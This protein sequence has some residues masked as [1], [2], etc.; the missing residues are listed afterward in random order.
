MNKESH[1]KMAKPMVAFL[2]PVILASVLQSL[3]QVFGIIYV[4]QALGVESL[5]AISAF[6]PLFFFLISFAIGIGS[7]SSILVGQTYGGGNISKM[8]E[9]VGVTLAFT[10]TISIGV[11]VFGTLFTENILKWMGTPDDILLISAGYARILFITLPITF[12]YMVYTTFMRGVGDSK[13]PFYFLLVSV[14]TNIILLPISISGWFGFPKQGLNGAAYAA[15]LSSFIAFLFLMGYLYKRGHILKLDSIILKNFRL[16][17]PILKSLLKLAIPTSI[18]MVAISMSEIAVITFVNDYG[19]HATAAYGIVNQ[20]ASYVQIP[21]MSISIAMS[22]FVAQAVG[23]G[24]FLQINEVSRVGIKLNYLLGGILI[25]IVYL[26]ADPILNIFLDHGET[27]KIA[28][29]LIFISF[30]GYAILGHTMSL[31]AKM[32]ATGT[33]LWP[34]IFTIASIWLIQVPAAYL[35]SS[36]TSLGINGVWLAYPIAFLTNFFVQSMYHYFYWKKKSLKALLN[37]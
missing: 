13:T 28:K 7:G 24:K 19:F 14:V 1:A 5:A 4:G 30:W 2:I 35:L 18:S 15:V 11:S 21:A 8:K 29:G 22:V 25:L 32:R 3:G 27:I 12:L 31:S 34:T 16:K 26:L 10:L 33:V 37:E 17:G 23:S 6:F 20:L 9:V 36:Y